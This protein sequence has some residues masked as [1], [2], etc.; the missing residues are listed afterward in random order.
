MVENVNDLVLEQLK[1][2]NSSIG[3]LQMAVVEL[4]QQIGSVD[5]RLSQL[6]RCVVNWYDNDAH[7]RNRTVW[8]QAER[9]AFCS[10]LAENSDVENVYSLTKPDD[11]TNY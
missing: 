11:G 5:L 3:Q 6:E 9:T 4:S 10:W 8:T 1:Q 7:N 2:I